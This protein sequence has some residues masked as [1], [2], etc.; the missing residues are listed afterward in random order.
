M[1][2][3]E[4]RAKSRGH[5][6]LR[7]RPYGFMLR[8]P[9]GR[10]WFRSGRDD[11]RPVAHGFIASYVHNSVDEGIGKI[12]VLVALESSGKADEL[13]RFGRMVAMHI[14][15]S[16]PQAIDSA[17]SRIAASRTMARLVKG[18]KKPL[19]SALPESLM[20]S[21]GTRRDSA[22]NPEGMAP[23]MGVPTCDRGL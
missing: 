1:E 20:G 3:V 14:A 22:R 10:L 9:G 4:R 23:S 12:G 13:K 7:S 2:N 16:N 6:C 11:V 8:A 5:G 18:M 19:K 15:A 17:D 21:S